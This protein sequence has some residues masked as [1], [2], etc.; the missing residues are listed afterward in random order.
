MRDIKQH[1]WIIALLFLINSCSKKASEPIVARAG[2]TTISLS[3]FRDRYEFTPHILLTKNKKRNKK[4]ALISLLGEKIL[5]EEAYHRKLNNNEKFRTYAEQMQKEAVIEALFEKEVASKIKISDQEVKQGFFLSQTELDLHVLSFDD[6]QQAQEAKKQIDAGRSFLQVK[7][8]FET[9]VFISADSVLTLTMKWGEAHPKLEDAAYKLNPNQVSEP[10]EADEMFFI[11]KLLQKRTNA[12]ITETDYLNQ[13][14]S[15][16]KKIKQRKRAEM[17]IEYMRALMM[18]KEM[19]VSHQIFDLVADELEKFYPIKDS[20]SIASKIEGFTEVIVDSLQNRTLA[21]H[22]DEPFARFNDGSVWTVGDFI[23][24][25]SVGPYRL[26]YQSKASF[27]NSL[28]RVIRR[29]A[30]FESLS[31]K[32]K[33]LGLEKTYY[34]RYQTKMWNDAYLAQQLRQEVIDTVDISDDEVRYYYH[35]HK[36]NYIG[37]E[38]VNLHEILVNDE[39]LANRIYQQI[40]NGEDIT[41]LAQKYNK[42]AISSKSDGVMGYFST[43][44]LG[45]IG[46]IAKNLKIGEIGGPVKTRNNQYS[47]FKVLDKKQRGPLPLEDVWDNVKQDALTDKRIRKIDDFLLQLADKYSIKVEQAVLDTMTTTDI[48][49]MVLKQHFPNRTAAPFVIP[50][51]K[52]YQ[53]QK[54]MEKIFTLNR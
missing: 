14:S 12:L 1:F 52:S 8:D 16:R 36:N 24:K 32:G 20:T 37:P 13:A 39:T 6:M 35:H 26:S 2:K 42:R 54:L 49:M 17:F 25:L 21:D 47:V 40:K 51:H 22:L 46:E 11:L 45:K 10:I 4:N 34:V 18:D 9:D 15:I 28:R 48:N 30:E 41:K 31:E 19:K 7:R 50:L 43:S 23:K 38:M 3:E 5:A 53:W 29:M 44:A 27:R 33:A